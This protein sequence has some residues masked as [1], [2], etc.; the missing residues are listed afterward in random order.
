MHEPL[1]WEGPLPRHLAVILDG[2]GR[3]A[4]ARDM[5]RVEGH[6][7][8]ADA[9]RTLVRTCRRLGIEALTLYA[10]SAQNWLRP[11]DEVMALMRL[12]YDYARSERG[13]ILDNDIRFSVVGDLERL[14]TWVRPVL[15][16]L[17][18]VSS[19]NHRMTLSLAVS[20]GGR[21][22]I[23][24]AA[25]R[26]A[27]SVAAGELDPADIDGER[28][29]NAMWTAHLP[30]DVDLVIRTGGDLR[31]SNFLLWQIAYA[32]LWFTDTLWPEFG[33]EHLYEALREFGRRERRYGRVLGAPA[34]ADDG[35]EG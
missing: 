8:G 34:A 29:S 21:E 9:V 4:T 28:L 6:R 25:R 16:E 31:V 32:E 33:T 11:T 35:T 26:L 13:E 24:A 17:M 2:N 1:P 10:F 27:E 15:D 5:P 14:P 18:K 22:E 7:R 23:V 12:L 20:Y 30:T 19:D 3:W